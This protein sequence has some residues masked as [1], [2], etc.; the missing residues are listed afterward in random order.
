MVFHRQDFPCTHPCRF[1]LKYAK[2]GLQKTVRIQTAGR[3]MFTFMFFS[4]NLGI[5]IGRGLHTLLSFR[6]S[7][8]SRKYSWI[9]VFLPPSPVALQIY[10]ESKMNLEQER[11]FICSAPGCSQVSVGILRS[12]F[13]GS[14]LPSKR[15]A[16]LS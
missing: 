15:E 13:Q 5:G 1:S 6:F 2:Y 12:V 14:H 16:T 4:S 9:S 3:P 8:G 10:E 11:P 7:G